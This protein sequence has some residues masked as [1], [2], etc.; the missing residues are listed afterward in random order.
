MTYPERVHP[1]NKEWLKIL[2]ENGP[3]VHPGANYVEK[4]GDEN[5][6]ISLRYAKRKL[7]ARDLKVRYLRRY[8]YYNDCFLEITQ[9]F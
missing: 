5:N 8:K 7:A 1:S 6:K 9:N 4:Q 3:D 2:V